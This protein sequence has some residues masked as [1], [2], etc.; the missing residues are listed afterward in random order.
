[1]KTEL[2][3]LLAEFL[4]YSQFSRRLRPATIRGYENHI[5]VFLK[6]MPAIKNPS[7]LDIDSITLFLKRLQVRKRIVGKGEERTGVKDSTVKAYWTRLNAFFNWMVTRGHLSENPLQSMSCPEPKHD[8]RKSFKKAD[9]EKLVTAI[10][11]NSKD[12]FMLRRDLAILY[13]LLFTGVRKGELL[14]MKISDI[15]LTK[16][17]I[18]VSAESSKSKAT[19]SIPINPALLIALNDYLKERKFK[20]Y[21]TEYLFA[22][23]NKDERL[24]EHGIKHWVNRIRRL[25][26]VNFHLH[27]FRHTFAHNLGNQNVGAIKVQKLMGHTD[28]RMTERYLR[29]MTV[30]D[31][32]SDVSK[33][34]IDS[35]V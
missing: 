15:D 6:L 18:K 14:G 11:L 1:M 28:L 31:L 24:T 5:G 16:E 13:T 10:S 34:G 4:R 8:D 26:G 23:S 25:S 17:N 2:Q 30:D 19:R 22:S 27:M 35:L 32:R 3:K 21:K 7:D 12:T 29:S 20:G 33:L 9:I